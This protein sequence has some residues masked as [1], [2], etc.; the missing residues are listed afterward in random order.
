MRGIQK[1]KDAGDL[2]VIASVSGGKDS[3]ALMLALREANIPFTAVFADTGWEAPETYAYLDLLRTKVAPIEVV[4]PA[5]DMVASIRHRA[6]FPGRMQRWCTRELKLVPLRAFHDASGAETISAMGVRAEES[7][8]RARM[9]EWEDSDDWGGFVWRPLLS[10]TIDDVIAIHKRHGVPMNPLYHQGFD[11]VGCFPCIFAR[12]E[13]IRLLPESRIDEIERLESECTT[14]RAERNAVTPD[15]YAH[16]Q[17]TFFQTKDVGRIMTI[18]D[19]RAWSQTERG[20]KQ[21]PILQPVPSGG[22]MRWGTCEAP[23]MEKP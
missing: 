22:C 4:R 23:P 8:T 7:E 21:F 11:R 5:R 15:R 3:T 13:E 20:G 17:A 18:R 1:P 9:P 12:K 14:L 6:G 19:V 2:L 10:W 16:A